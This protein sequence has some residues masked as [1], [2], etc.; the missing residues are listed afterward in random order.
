MKKYL[1]NTFFTFNGV[2]DERFYSY[3][4]EDNTKGEILV[5]VNLEQ[6]AAE[7]IHND[8]QGNN[9]SY[10]VYSPRELQDTIEFILGR[11]VVSEDQWKQA[12]SGD[13][14]LEAELDDWDVI[15]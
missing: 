4:T 3:S 2:V 5:E 6:D 9:Y 7:I 15:D 11:K 13:I 10:E 8:L 1:D 12:T 14:S